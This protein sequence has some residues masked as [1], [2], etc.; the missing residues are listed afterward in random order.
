MP[1]TRAEGLERTERGF[2]KALSFVGF[3]EPGKTL[4]TGVSMQL[5]KVAWMANLPYRREAM[6][7][8][9]NWNSVFDTEGLCLLM[10]IS[11]D[12]SE[13]SDHGLVVTA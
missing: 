11:R 10:E 3:V 1:P 13:G 5:A 7:N 8:S 2:R 9:G 12:G 6:R 4:R